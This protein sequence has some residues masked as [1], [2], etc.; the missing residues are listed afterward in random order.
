MLTHRPFS[1]RK[2]LAWLAAAAPTS[3]L[4]QANPDPSPALAELH[5]TTG[6]GQPIDL[7]GLRGRVVLV[8]FWSTE[9]PVCRSKMPELRANAAGWQTQNFTLLG[10]NLDEEE[11]T[12]L[13][14]EEVVTPLLPAAQ[15]F[16]S[17]WGLAPAYKDNLGAEREPPSA[18]LIDK[19]GWVVER[20]S[21]RIPPQAWDRIADLL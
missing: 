16:P 1:R 7:A 14:Y 2:L 6:S 21:G 4:A 13:R 19:D 9:C 17:V 12:F 10:V 8:F 20:Y 5:G 18:V 3:L 11:S 15:R